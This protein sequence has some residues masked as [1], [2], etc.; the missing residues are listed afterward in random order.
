MHTMHRTAAIT[1][2]FHRDCRV[3][4]QSADGRARVLEMF[5]N[6]AKKI[7]SYPVVF[8]HEFPENLPV[9]NSLKQCLFY[10]FRFFFQKRRQ[11]QRLN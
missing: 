11:Q 1:E 5:K 3:R 6:C 7:T 2:L 8:V 10:F 4:L 9:Y